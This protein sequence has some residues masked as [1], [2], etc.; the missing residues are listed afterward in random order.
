MF[1]TVTTPLSQAIPLTSVTNIGYNYCKQW[2]TQ[3]LSTSFTPIYAG[4]RHTMFIRPAKLVGNMERHVL[5]SKTAIQDNVECNNE[6]KDDVIRPLAHFAPDIWGNSFL[7]FSPQDS[8]NLEKYEIEVEPLRE[9]V[10]KWLKD[11]WMEISKKMKLIDEV[12]R[13]GVYY[14]YN[15]EIEDSLRKIYEELAVHNFRNLEFDLC[16]TAT[17]FRVLRQHG[18]KVPCDIFKKFTN[19]EGKF[20]ESISKDTKGILSLYEAAHVRIHGDDILDEAIIFTTNILKSLSTSKFSKQAT[21]ALKQ[22]LH[23]GNPRDECR[24]FVSFYEDDEYRNETLLKFAKI[25]YNRLQLIHR[26]EL[27]QIERWWRALDLEKKLPYARQRSV[28]C[29]YCVTIMY[30]EPQYSFA[31]VLLTKIFLILSVL[32][33]TYDAYGTFDELRLLTQA[34]ERWD[35]NAIEELPE[36]YMKVVYS[37]VLDTC[38]EFAMEMSKRGKSFAAKYT[39]DRIIDLVRSYYNETK[40]KKTRYMPTFEEYLVNAGITSAVQLIITSS[41]MGM[42]EIT[43]ENQYQLMIQPSKAITA[44]ELLGR[45]ADDIAGHEEEQERG[46]FA[47]SV[48][49]YMH[50]YK[51][52][53]EETIAILKKMMDDY[54]KQMNEELLFEANSAI[55]RPVLIRI[56][57][58]CRVGDVIYKGIDGYTHSPEVLKDVVLSTYIKPFPI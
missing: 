39:I 57:N 23:F 51:K 37:F 11:G 53:K 34:F 2:H 3:N 29:L 27:S 22:A 13:L 24:Q 15:D 46:D 47:S 33:D 44:C 43:D 55:Q 10:R 25:E 35:V 52:S 19:G 4:F 36:D 8:L 18:Y 7:H 42:D 16:D 45:F 58:L 38:G 28:E 26:Q 12:E 5:T 9:E 48:E 50:N 21:H 6:V 14:Y 54:W 56:L 32:D 41:M 1:S 40:W 49:C 17:L 31:R 30:F 20:K